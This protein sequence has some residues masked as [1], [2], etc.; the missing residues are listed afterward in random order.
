[1]S[2]DSLGGG[3]AAEGGAAP[4]ERDRGSPVP[5]APVRSG[6]EITVRLEG[7]ARRFG[8]QV[9][10]D[11]IIA[12]TRKKETLDPH[13]LKQWLLEGVD[14]AFAASVEPGDILVAGEAFGCGSAM[15][16]SVTVVKAAGIP[17]VLAN[18]FART[19]FRNAINNALLP[20]E[21][22]TSGIAE[23]DWL[24]VEV[25]GDGVR[26]H[27]Q[28]DDRR[29]VARP[30]PPFI[31]DILAAGGLAP[32]LRERGGFGTVPSADPAAP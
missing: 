29:R 4:L 11:Y 19:Y 31:L 2:Q 22:D 20:I 21:C 15:E 24:V 23:G 5:G 3:S 10:T 13:E 8:D 18:S 27:V 25:T 28:G 17:A 30:F 1:M 9:N 6:P 14:P 32:F 12:S 26:I 7:R 16:V